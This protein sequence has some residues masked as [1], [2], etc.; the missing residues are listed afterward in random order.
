MIGKNYLTHLKESFIRYKET[1]KF[2]WHRRE[3]MKMLELSAFEAEFLPA[4]LSVQAAPVSPAGRWVARI[5][6]TLIIVLLI[7]SIFGKVDIIINAQGKIIAGGYTKT[8]ASVAVAKVVALHVQEGQSVKSGD[9]LVELDAR[10]SDSEIYKADNDR[11]LSLLQME[12][13]KSFLFSL[14]NNSKPNLVFIDGVNPN[15]YQNEV[16]HLADQWR[17]YVAKKNRLDTQIKRFADALP[18]ALRRSQDFAEL[19]NSHDVTSHSYLE[20]LQA[21]I[22]LQ[23]Q[24]NDQKTQLAVLLAE[25]RKNAQDDLYQAT[26][27]WSGTIQD[28]KKTAA[29]SDQLRIV[30]PVDGVVQQLSIHTVGGVVPIAQPLM[31][32]VPDQRKVELDAYVENKDIGFLKEGQQAQVKIDAYDYTKYGTVPAIVAHISRDAVDSSSNM[33]A[34]GPG[35]DGKKDSSRGLFYLVK[36]ILQS[37]N[38]FVDGKRMALSPGMSGSVE[39]K[40]GDRRIIEYVLSPLMTH[41]RESLHER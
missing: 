15:F 30:S 27:I 20:K 24:L 12:R 16:I 4:A 23:G 40:T 10:E 28:I 17:D 2:W 11:Q 33:L 9:L 1:F 3:K 41:A 6:I 39:I 19:A 21:S 37:P 32:I 18:L 31:F 29:R 8:V 7:W 25:T 14:E 38:I 36:V 35:N 26:R 34:A 13:S 5:I 22:D